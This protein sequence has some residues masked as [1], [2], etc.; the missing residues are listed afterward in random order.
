MAKVFLWSRL[1][2]IVLGQWLFAPACLCA[3]QHLVQDGWQDVHLLQVL[4]TPGKK[5]AQVYTGV[6]RLYKCIQI[7]ERR[8]TIIKCF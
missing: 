4:C 1:P 8:E 6:Y 7:R 2:W 5:T 3:Q